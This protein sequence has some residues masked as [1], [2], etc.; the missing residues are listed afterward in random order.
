MDKKVKAKIQSITKGAAKQVG[1]AL[2]KADKGATKA[3]KVIQKKWKDSEP[4]RK[5]LEKK[6]G[7]AAKKAEKKGAAMLKSGIK[8]SIKIGGDVANVIKK[9]LKE[10]NKKKRK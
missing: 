1:I 3:A 8:N 4:Q 2:K 9:D 7:V 5:V 6:I 10:I